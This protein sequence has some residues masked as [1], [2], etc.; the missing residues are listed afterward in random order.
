MF[1]K[2]THRSKRFQHTVSFPTVLSN[3][4][5]ELHDHLLI[6]DTGPVRLGESD[7]DDGTEHETEESDD[8]HR[9]RDRDRDRD[10][11]KFL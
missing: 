11:D 10:A 6:N 2:E 9:D 5:P 1:I 4:G 8:F 3:M 7:E